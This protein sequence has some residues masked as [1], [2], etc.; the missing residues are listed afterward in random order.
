[1]ETLG[2]RIELAAV[3]WD[4][5]EKLLGN[6]FLRDIIDPRSNEEYITQVLE[7]EMGRVTKK[8]PHEFS[9]AKS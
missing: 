7:K 5:Q 1:M 9:R 2:N 6:I 4:S 3:N 8:V